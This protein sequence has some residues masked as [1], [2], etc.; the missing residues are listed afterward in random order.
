M[1]EAKSR[2]IV[3]EIAKIIVGSILIAIVYG[4]CHDMVTAHTDISYFTIFHP[5][6]ID[7]YSPVDMALLWG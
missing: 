2:S 7:S 1:S 5:H 4:I 3:P 6:I